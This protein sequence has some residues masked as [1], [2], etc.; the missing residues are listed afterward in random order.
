MSQFDL[1]VNGKFHYFEIAKVLNKRGLLNKIYTTYPKYHLAGYGIPAEKVKS[2][3]FFEVLR[4][5]FN[6]V[7]FF[8]KDLNLLQ[9]LLFGYFIRFVYVH[10][11]CVA[12]LFLAGNFCSVPLIKKFR[13]ARFTNWFID[14]GSSHVLFRNSIVLEEFCRLGIKYELD[15]S[16]LI[17]WT[18]NE[19]FC[20]KRIFVPSQFVNDSFGIFRLSHKVEVN[21]YGYSLN[22]DPLPKKPIA[23]EK[24][25]VLFVGTLMIR[26]GV[27]L[28][29]E[30]I[31]NLDPSKFVFHFAGPVRD[32]MQQFIHQMQ[33]SSNV[34]FYGRLGR[35]RLNELYQLADVLLLPSIE[36]GLSLVQLEAL[37][38]SVPIVASRNTGSDQCLVDNVNGILIES[39]STLAIEN[40]LRRLSEN[41]DFLSLLK[42]NARGS[43]DRFTW[44]N[45]VDKLESICVR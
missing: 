7:P 20:A 1:I 15:R 43:I 6:K 24:L 4:R 37:S 29:I 39:F 11:S 34:S 44:E 5:I 12:V 36:E 42:A 26:K 33:S 8:S 2:L 23:G 3:V 41:P 35:D 38:R 31:N 10:R 22:T 14:E 30:A 17:S 18:L 21:P 19:Y 32:E 40:A 27:H 13:R 28:I 25:N 9:K 16:C 45:Y